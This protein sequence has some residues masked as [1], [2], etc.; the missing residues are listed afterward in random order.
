MASESQITVSPA[1]S[2]G[3]RPEAEY[4]AIR[5]A[6]SGVSSGMRTSLN[7]MLNAVIATQGRIDQDE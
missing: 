1:S 2:S 7:G 6:V 5:L 4:F 3:T